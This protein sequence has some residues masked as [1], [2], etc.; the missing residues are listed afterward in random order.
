MKN[1]H[2]DLKRYTKDELIS[3]IGH[4]SF[5]DTRRLE[6]ALRW[7]QNKKEEQRFAEMDRYIAL[8]AAKRQEYIDLMRPY[9]GQ[10]L[11]DIPQEVLD[12]AV[13]LA[14][15]AEEA[16]KKYLELSRIKGD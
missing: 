6:G 11:L 14:R 15:A 1:Y 7:L 5:A 16:D 9:T 3:I 4:M 10:S 2:H 8:S 13:V 12:K